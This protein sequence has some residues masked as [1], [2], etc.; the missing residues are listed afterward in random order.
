MLD[1]LGQRRDVRVGGREPGPPPAVGASDRARRRNSSHRGKG[2]RTYSS[3]RTSKSDVQSPTGSVL[4]MCCLLG[5][6]HVHL[7][8]YR[9]PPSRY[10]QTL[11]AGRYGGHPTVRAD[12]GSSVP[13]ERSRCH[14]QADLLDHRLG[15]RLRGGRRRGVRMGGTGRGGVR[16]RQRPRAPDRHLPLRPPDVRDD[17]LLGDGHRRSRSVAGRS[18]VRRHLAGRRQGRLLHL[19]A[20]VSSARTRDRAAFDPGAVRR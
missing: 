18:R 19:A 9:G 4:A 20:S 11:G 1:V 12:S 14:G 13:G 16:L 10:A 8:A 6:G 5:P 15:R 2:S 17:G 3:S 7:L